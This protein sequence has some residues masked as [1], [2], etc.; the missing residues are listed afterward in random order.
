MMS[1]PTSILI[2]TVVLLAL[3]GVYRLI[4][5]W[6]MREIEVLSRDQKLLSS[7]SLGLS[8]RPDRLIRLRNGA[9]IPK[10]KKSSKRL[11][12]SHRIQVGAYLLLVEETYGVRPLYG[13][14]VLDDGRE[15]KIK[16]TARL[17]RWTLNVADDIRAQRA[18][19]SR[20]TRVWPTPRQCRSCAVRD[21]CTQRAT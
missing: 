20:P 11:Y 16:N 12:D 9:I 17:R 15:A 18:D 2:L 19:A 8:G 3:I 1:D 5:A 21:H 4:R 7:T 13:V 10:E 6:Q 14:V